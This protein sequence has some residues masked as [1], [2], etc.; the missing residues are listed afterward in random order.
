MSRRE[1]FAQPEHVVM[2][3]ADDAVAAHLG[4]IG[5]R[6]G[7]GDGIIVHIQ[8]DEEG[9]SGRGRTG[10]GEPRWTGGFRRGFRLDGWGV[11]Q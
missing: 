6:Q 9:R 3:A 5:G 1:S 2:R 10:L 11:F 4:G 8:A 7:D